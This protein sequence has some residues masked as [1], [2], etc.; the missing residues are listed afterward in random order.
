MLVFS[1]NYFLQ[2]RM[3]LQQTA[4]KNLHLKRQ[5]KTTNMKRR[6]SNQT[7]K[8]KRNI[9]NVLLLFSPTKR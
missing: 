3:P 1:K 8:G 6:K 7:K 4:A 2:W 9:A 5:A